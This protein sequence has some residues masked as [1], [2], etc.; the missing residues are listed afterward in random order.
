MEYADF[1]RTLMA[2]TVAF[3]K[4]LSDPKIELMWERMRDIPMDTLEQAA[5]NL[6]NTEKRFPSIATWRQACD[7]VAQTT[8]K[9]NALAAV[10][11]V[12]DQSGGYHCSACA[13]TGWA[14][15]EVPTSSL[16]NADQRARNPHTSW[17]RRCECWP[18]NPHRQPIAAKFYEGHREGSRFD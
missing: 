10:K 8:A 18:T 4:E 2:M 3:D 17:A 5:N 7:A 14:I 11:Q 12:E 13:D 9:S 15:F 1:A 16:Y 6:I